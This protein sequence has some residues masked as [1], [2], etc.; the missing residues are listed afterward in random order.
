MLVLQNKLF[1][2]RELS[3]AG[4]P[5]GGHIGGYLRAAVA[6]RAPAMA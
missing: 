4:R 3:S 1:C 6:P 5:Q 2:T